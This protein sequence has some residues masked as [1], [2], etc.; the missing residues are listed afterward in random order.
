MIPAQSEAPA[1]HPSSTMEAMLT[2][3]SAAQV[4]KKRW[5][6]AE[7]PGVHSASTAHSWVLPNVIQQASIACRSHGRPEMRPMGRQRKSHDNGRI[8]SG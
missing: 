6:M 8:H 7:V 2:Y 1:P 3:S 5:S 4:A